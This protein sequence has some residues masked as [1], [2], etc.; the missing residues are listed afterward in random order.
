[1]R[2]LNINSSG[3]YCRQLKIWWQFV[4]F[5][6][7]SPCFGDSCEN[8]AFN[9]KHYDFVISD[10]V[11]VK[12]ENSI[13]FIG[14]LFIPNL[15]RIP[16]ESG[17]IKLRDEFSCTF[18]D[19]YPEKI[20]FQDKK[21]ITFGH[22]NIIKIYN[23]DT[24]CLIGPLET[25]ITSAHYDP[26]HKKLYAGLQNGVLYIFS[27]DNFC[28]SINEKNTIKKA[29]H[30]GKINSIIE[31]GEKI[32]TGGADG[33]I[34]IFDQGSLDNYQTLK[35]PTGKGISFYDKNSPS[36]NSLYYCQSNKS[37]YAA[38]GGPLTR[39]NYPVMWNMSER[40]PIL[41]GNNDEHWYV[42][43][44]GLEGKYT[45]FAGQRGNIKIYSNQTNQLYWEFNLYKDTFVEKEWKERIHNI[46]DIE[47]DGEFKSLITTHGDN[48]M[49]L[50]AVII[51]SF[52]VYEKAINWKGAV[53]LNDNNVEAC[54]VN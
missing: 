27:F 24:P 31:E 23:G 30:I 38:Y 51:W 4:L 32:Y 44:L 17:N 43:V 5:L 1:M 40:K 52:N 7:A 37:L 42:K 53:V 50:S 22:K 35:F 41:L 12:E 45:L 36:V 20:I 3:K 18:D 47:Y 46:N 16:Y 39:K 21:L 25:D 13:F 11:I 48:F 8:Y 2:R 33:V 54:T 9:I 14:D 34:N 49:N 6:L 29:V 15:F 26:K 19:I 28:G 10:S